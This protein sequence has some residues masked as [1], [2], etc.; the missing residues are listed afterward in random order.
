[1]SMPFSQVRQQSFK[2]YRDDAELVELDNA[3]LRLVF[4]RRRPVTPPGW[5]AGIIFSGDEK[6]MPFVSRAIDGLREQPEL[7]AARGGQIMV[8]GPAA[9]RSLSRCLGRCRIC[10]LRGGPAPSGPS[11]RARRMR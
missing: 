11:R 9:A 6:E 5:S 7:S 4:A 3:G 2:I 10:R 1:M 8:C